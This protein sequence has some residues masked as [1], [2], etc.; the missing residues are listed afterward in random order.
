MKTGRK[1]FGEELKIKERYAALTEPYFRELMAFLNSDDKLD[2]K[3]A[4]AELTKAYIR[5]IPQQLTGEGGGAIIFQI[6]P[7]IA[8]KNKLYEATQ[9]SGGDSQGQSP[10]QSS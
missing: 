4:I 9:M 8:E 7:E 6:A 1:G 5:M 10:V 2:K 3:F